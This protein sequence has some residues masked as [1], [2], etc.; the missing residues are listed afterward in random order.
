MA[1]YALDGEAPE[2]PADGLYWVAETAVVD[3]ARAAPLRREHL[4]GLGLARRQ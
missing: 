1:I 2:F 3:R 4:V